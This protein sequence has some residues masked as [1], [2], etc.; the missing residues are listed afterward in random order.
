[1]NT[2]LVCHGL[3]FSKAS[4]SRRIEDEASEWIYRAANFVVVSTRG[5][6]GTC[7]KREAVQ[8]VDE[9]FLLLPSGMKATVSAGDETIS[10]DGDSLFIVPPGTSE[11]HLLENGWVHRIFSCQA[12]DLL[13]IATNRDAYT[14]PNPA[15]APLET[16][17]EAVGGYKLRHYALADYV[18]NDT[19]MRLFRT[20]HL[21]IN[22]FCPSPSP[23]DIRKMTPHAHKDFEQGSLV[24][25]GEFVHHLRYP[26]TADKTT[27]REDQHE[28]MGAPSLVVI[29]PPVIHTSQSLGESSVVRM[30][31]L[32][33]PPRDDF[34]LK[35][36]LVCNESEYPLPDRLRNAVAN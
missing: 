14:E 7:L 28:H 19:S 6:S 22:V 20:R 11:V 25:D 5:S 10:S 3:D 33:A 31:D 35:P 9:Y 23:R 17:P 8:Q 24:L 18:R 2:S 30:V 36:G 34:S 21:M 1:M 29:P 26:W 13:A 12:E 27:W 4:P 15:V 32:F 16:W